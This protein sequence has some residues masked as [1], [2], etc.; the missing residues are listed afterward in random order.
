MSPLPLWP[1]SP[2]CVLFCLVPSSGPGQQKTN[3]ASK[4]RVPLAGA[5]AGDMRV[6]R[7][8][9]A[10]KIANQTHFAV[11][12]DAADWTHLDKGPV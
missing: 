3:L 1:A 6:L 8:Q 4:E 7:C 10:I 12:V 2:T 9:D 5:G 11:A